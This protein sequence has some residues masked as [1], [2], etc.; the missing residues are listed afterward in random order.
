LG[1]EIRVNGSCFRVIVV[2]PEGFRG[3]V[4]GSQ[5]SSVFIPAAMFPV[6]YRYC[7]ATARDC[8]L[9]QLIGRL[10]PHASFG[11]AQAE[12]SAL[13]SRLETTFPETNRGRGV[14]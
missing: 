7:D 3:A 11:D 4:H 14:Q 6:G 1:A 10:K 5:P 8:R 9:V 13:A 12:M 2:C